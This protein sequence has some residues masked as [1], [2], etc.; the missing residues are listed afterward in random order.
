MKRFGLIG[1]IGPESTIEYY[2][3]I[4][5]RFQELSGTS[6]CPEIVIYS[7]NMTEMLNYVFR[8]QLGVLVE[9]LARKIRLLEDAGVDYGALA[10]N[11]PHLVF[12]RLIGEVNIPLV[13]IVEE[14]CRA[15]AEQKV[16][17][18]AL[19][20]TKSTMTAGFYGQTAEKHEIEI[21]V[22]SPENQDYVHD[23][24]MT[25]LIFNKIRPETKQRLIQIVAESKRRDSIEGL[26][27]G[28]TELPLVLSQADFSDIQIF[29]TMKIHVDS[30]VTKMFEP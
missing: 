15:M 16:R 5:K 14:T 9:Y 19:L 10:S 30:I 13:S 2:R 26:I 12:D 28:G 27:L 17:K 3:L 8:G 21:V 20:G 7:I 25:E 24:Y 4:I 18:A 1:G 29:D 22:P 6:D 23:K 11:T